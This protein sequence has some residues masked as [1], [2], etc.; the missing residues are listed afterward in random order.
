MSSDD[1]N[2]NVAPFFKIKEDEK[3]RAHAL[4]YVLRI[5]VGKKIKLNNPILKNPSTV[6]KFS[7]RTWVWKAPSDLLH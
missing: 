2:I 7:Y 6:R 5:P 3:W 1:N 4:E